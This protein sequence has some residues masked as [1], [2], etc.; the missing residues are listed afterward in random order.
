MGVEAQRGL[1]NQSGSFPVTWLGR[2]RESFRGIRGRRDTARETAPGRSTWIETGRTQTWSPHV[3]SA[4]SQGSQRLEEGPRG[5]ARRDLAEAAKRMASGHRFDLL[6]TK[7][8]RTSHPGLNA[9]V[10]RPTRVQAPPHPRQRAA[11]RG[12]DGEAVEEPA[13]LPLVWCGDEKHRLP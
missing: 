11:W 3:H 5:A 10:V 1:G 6:N 13:S 8:K 2:R 7:E 4:P 12:L 9:A